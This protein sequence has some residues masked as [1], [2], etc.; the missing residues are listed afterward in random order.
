M[1]ASDN[2]RDPFYAYGDLDMM[3]VWREGVRILQLDYPFADWAEAVSA[4]PARA[5]GLDPGV[6]H[7]GAAANMILTRARDFT[8]L[9]A[10]PQSDRIVVRNGEASKAEPP[11]YA[12]LDALEGLAP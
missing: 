1:I 8:E 11:D 6:L 5:M 9:L 10:R 2:T 7:P 12:E 3:E 4:S